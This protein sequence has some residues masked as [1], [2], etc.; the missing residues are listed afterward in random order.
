MT[1]RAAAMST[2]LAGL[3]SLQMVRQQLRDKKEALG[4]G[5]FLDLCNRLPPISLK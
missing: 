3:F 5:P 2:H 1:Q 4:T